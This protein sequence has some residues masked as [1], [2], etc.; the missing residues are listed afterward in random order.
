MI[1]LI[2]LLL[3]LTTAAVAQEEP[4]MSTRATIQ[5]CVYLASPDP[6]PNIMGANFEGMCAG[7]ILT[8]KRYAGICVPPAMGA[9]EIANDVLTVIKTRAALYRDRDIR[10]VIKDVMTE[11]Y[12]CP[13]S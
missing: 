9:A 8:H 7:I 4:G 10:D 5:G 2:F 12:A 6:A 3:S 11:V 1:R 13:K